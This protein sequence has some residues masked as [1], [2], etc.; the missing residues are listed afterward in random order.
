LFDNKLGWKPH[1]AKLTT[2]LPNSFGILSKL[3]HYTNQTLLKAVNNALIHPLSKLRCVE[4]GQ[5]FKNCYSISCEFTK[6]SC[7]IYENIQNRIL[8]IKN[9]FKLSAGKFIHFYK[10]NLIP[11]HFNLYLKSVQTVHNYPT[12]LATSKSFFLPRITSSQRQY[13]LKFMDP[14][15]DQKHLTISS[16]DLTLTLNICT[17]TNYSL[18]L[19]VQ[20]NKWYV[21][22][23]SRIVHSLWFVPCVF[24]HYAFLCILY[25]ADTVKFPFLMG[26]VFFICVGHLISFQLVFYI[27]LSLYC[28]ANI[29]SFLCFVLSTPVK[30]NISSWQWR[31]EAKCCLR[32]TIIVPPFPPLKFAYNK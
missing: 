28:Q 18:A 26:L 25:L 17:K 21:P 23:S 12:R 13:F 32:P 10:N 30:L 27:V 24:F 7:E 8:S 4:V 2:Q 11:S 15:C 5:N 29:H 1:V 16:F 9:L 22:N 19:L 31:S 6:Q 20:S 3:R 14:R